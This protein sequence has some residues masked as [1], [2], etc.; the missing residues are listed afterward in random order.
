[1]KE[2]KRYPCWRPKRI[3]VSG[4]LAS[5]TDRVVREWENARFFG[6]QRPHQRDKFLGQNRHP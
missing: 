4:K 2:L 6:N 5:E 1:M 3:L